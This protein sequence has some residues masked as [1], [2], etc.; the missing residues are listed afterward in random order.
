MPQ[1]FVFHHQSTQPQKSPQSLWHCF[2]VNLYV[3]L[4][5]YTYVMDSA[6]S[7]K[8]WAARPRSREEWLQTHSFYPSFFSLLNSLPTAHSIYPP[9]SLLS[10]FI[11]IPLQTNAQNISICLPLHLF[12]PFYVPIFFIFLL[13]YHSWLK[14]SSWSMALLP[15]SSPITLTER[16][17]AKL[18]S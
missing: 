10:L 7:A 13:S 3:C 8:R 15:V 14:F 6:G 5:G 18:I 12:F 1:T 11:F 17:T 9:H 16:D 4:Q 2:N